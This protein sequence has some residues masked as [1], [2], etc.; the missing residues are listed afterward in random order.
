VRLRP[1]FAHAGGDATAGLDV[2]ARRA[3]LAFLVL[4]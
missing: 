2:E 4:L 1:E 3:L